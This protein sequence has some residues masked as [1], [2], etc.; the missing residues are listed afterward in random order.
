[1]LPESE[2]KTKTSRKRFFF[3][4]VAEHTPFYLSRLKILR[5]KICM[6]V[7]ML[8]ARPGPAQ[9]SPARIYFHPSIAQT[10]LARADTT[11]STYMHYWV[12]ILLCAKIK[13]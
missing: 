11:Q 8:A 4:V 1:M 2:E 5:I 6:S 12:Y 9:P 10:D 13:K 7:W 3:F